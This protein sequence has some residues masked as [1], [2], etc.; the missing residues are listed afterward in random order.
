MATPNSIVIK[1]AA[2]DTADWQAVLDLV[3]EAFAYMEGLIDPPSSAYRLTVEAMAAQTEEGTV[4]MAEGRDGT[5]LGCVFLKPKGDALYL[6]KLAIRP[7]RQAEG[8]GRRL[9]E[10][11]IEE[12]R[13]RNLPEIELQARV[14]LTENHAAFAAMG[15]REV[16]RTAHDGYDR[17]T[18]VTMRYT[19]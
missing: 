7:A 9:F 2:A 14:E 19:I 4:F 13:A 3:R 11:G 17:P 1:R 15:F 6:G 5:L 10:A 8:I 18:S 12:A 16:G